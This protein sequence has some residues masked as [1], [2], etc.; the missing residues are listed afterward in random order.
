MY[1]KATPTTGATFGVYGVTVSDDPKAAG[2]RARGFGA[3]GLVAKSSDSVGV[4][5]KPSEG[6]ASGIRGVN[7]AASNP[8]IVGFGVEGETGSLGD[9]AAGVYGKAAGST[10]RTLGVRGVTHSDDARAAG[11]RGEAPASGEGTTEGV[12][13][14][15]DAKGTFHNSVGFVPAAGVHGEAKSTSGV[16]DNAGVRGTNN[17]SSGRGYGVIGETVS[18]DSDAAG[19]YGIGSGEAAAVSALGRVDITDVGLS[20]WLTANQT[21]PG[22]T[23]ET[24]V[25]DGVNADDFDGYNSSTGVYTVQ[26]AGDYHVDVMLNWFDNLTGNIVSYVLL[27]N[28]I[29]YRGIKAGLEE[30][31][32]PSR[33]HSKTVFGLKPGDTLEV[34]VRHDSS[35]TKDLKG[36][37]NAE[38]TY[39]TIH[40]VG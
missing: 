6:S 11:V 2:I 12:K 5:G 34:E 16:V 36:D 9:G 21:I 38:E 26:Q 1:G 17:S 15:T 4:S 33:S 30:R 27:V 25:F 20:A 32:I 40:K 37:S 22:S 39:L 14:E 23:N 28:D 13:G 24:V 29:H 3:P 10:G 8:T 31:G 7:Q 35:E 18:D 19:V